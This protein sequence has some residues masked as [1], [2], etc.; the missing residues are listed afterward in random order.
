MANFDYELVGQE[1]NRYLKVLLQAQERGLATPQAIAD[2]LAA[3]LPADAQTEINA[4]LITSMI[5]KVQQERM[6]GVN[7]LAVSNE[8]KGALRGIVA[9]AKGATPPPSSGEPAPVV[10][11]NFERHGYLCFE[12]VFNASL[13]FWQ[14]HYLGE[15][16]DNTTTALGLVVWVNSHQ[17]IDIGALAEVDASGALGGLALGGPT[18]GIGLAGH[19]AALVASLTSQFAVASG[20]DEVWVD[21]DI[22]PGT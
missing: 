1:H 5:R 10:L 16:N 15:E 12:S 11:T 21:I 20:N 4:D 3:A 22:V 17:G 7:D 19:Y 18:L 8:L 14:S 6:N 2:T 13:D 9:K